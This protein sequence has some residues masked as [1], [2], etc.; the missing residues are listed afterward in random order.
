MGRRGARVAVR[1]GLRT[2]DSLLRVSS[3]MKRASPV[4][5]VGEARSGTS[6]LYRLLQQHP[7]F[8]PYRINLV[9]TH[10]FG[11]LRR[12]FL[13]KTRPPETLVRYMLGDA[14]AYRA[15]L[16]SIRLPR[17]L[18][19]VN[20]GVNWVL[21]DRFAWL[22]YANLN[23][24]VV[25]SYFFHAWRARGCRR[26]LE[27]T[28]TN[29]AYI[30][31]LT[32]IFPHA[33]LLYVH[34]HPVDVL[35]SY[36]RR[37]RDDPA[38][39]WAELDVAAFCERYAVSAGRVLDWRAAGHT[40]L[41]LVRYEDLTTEPESELSGVCAFLGEAFEPSVLS[42]RHPDPQRWWGD[43]HLWGDITPST[44]R[45]QDYVTPEEAR[46]VQDRLAPT[47]R[48]LGHEPHPL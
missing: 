48:R 8:R 39:V 32:A 1:P 27:K 47:M 23:H 19:A 25:R 22:W 18:S 11:Q 2:S 26:L 33:R 29:T 42:E 7:S 36:R 24:L 45:W 14:A 20:V 21:R 34:R 41:S 43:P 46:D 30:A 44:K 5:I 10:I 28:P 16:R 31:R 35:G 9:E 12:A 4:F 3:R 15:F 38:A 37:R 40:N 17:G 13:F 6:L